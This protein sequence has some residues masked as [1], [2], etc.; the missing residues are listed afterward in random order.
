[1]RLSTGWILL[2]CLAFVSGCSS[3]E[4]SLQGAR[5]QLNDFSGN[6]SPEDTFSSGSTGDSGNTAGLESDQLRVTLE[7]PAGLAPEG[8]PT[9]RGL[10]SVKP[11][12]IS[13][14]R[15]NPALQN[16]GAVSVSTTT[17]SNGAT[18]ITFADGLPSGPDIIIE[19]SYGNLQVQAPAAVA[20]QDVKINPFSDYL[21]RNTLPGY[22]TSE[23]QRILDCVDN[24]QEETCPNRYVW[25]ALADQVQD[26]E[27]DIPATASLE[28][29]R[30]LLAGRGDFSRYVSDMAGYAIPEIATSGDISASSADY[31]AVFMG[32]ELGQSFMESA[33]EGAGQ[34]GVRIARKETV[35]DSN[36]TSTV[37]PGLTLAS[38]EAFGIEMTALSGDVPYGRE[39]LIHTSGDHFF[40]R[41][42]GNW[43]TNSQASAPNAA[44][45][46]SGVRLRSGRAM[47]QSITGQDS[48]NI[49]GWTRNP[50]F[51]DAWTSSQESET[52]PVQQVM[53]GYFSAGKTIELE[54]DGDQYRRGDLAENH[55]LS[56]L[57]LD[58]IRQPGFT[59][60][61]LD[62]GQYHALYLAI[63]FGT[64]TPM[65]I[66]TGL[67]DWQITGDSL[68]QIRST[69]T[70]SRSIDGSVYISESA[71]L[72]DTWALSA[73]TPD[74]GRVFLDMS[75]NTATPEQYDL[76][77]GAATP[78]GDLLAFNLDDS[79]MGD[80]MLIAIPQTST[81]A[82]VSGQ[83]R[84]QGFALGLSRGGNH[85]QH[86]DNATLVIHSDSAATLYPRTLEVSHQVAENTVSTPVFINGEPLELNYSHTGNGRVLFTN[87]NLR[88]EGFTGRDN[89]P[90]YLQLRN[91]VADEEQFGLVLMTPLP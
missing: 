11:E 38:F 78:E 52:S 84:L 65:V 76:S 89:T 32:V 12:R 15:T 39:T 37:W 34:W 8:E 17:D 69:T 4:S 16:L 31:N 3:G 23:F 68:S 48:A 70:L 61:T 63:R 55:Y 81:A 51:M 42:S 5:N 54:A 18:I 47:Y 86:F 36:G 53:T 29:A 67:G 44:S 27:I 50:W 33:L 7:L 72:A 21:V 19:A 59:L 79:P 82:P 30:Q 13:V 71:G 9:R 91:T 1:M 83:Y 28:E 20:D 25:P 77:M 43:Q 22:S 85:L 88:L 90:F 40:P 87:G 14:Y 46:I 74:S 58:L 10:N 49:L 45:R 6:I 24:S 60:A 64:D 2:T 56:A 62:G 73:D 80:G 26:F 57:E 41:N 75:G 35:T 66:E